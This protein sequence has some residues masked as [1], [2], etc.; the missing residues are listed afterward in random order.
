MHA[1][2]TKAV[3]APDVTQKF[4]DQFN[5]EIVLSSPEQ[6]AAYQKEQELLVQGHQGQQHQAE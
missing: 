4:V 2:I 3:R 5:M 6:F 1:A